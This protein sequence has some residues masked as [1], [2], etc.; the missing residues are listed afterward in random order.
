MTK[1]TGTAKK[2][3][4]KVSK[5]GMKAIGAP[6]KAIGRYI[7]ATESALVPDMCRVRKMAPRNIA[8]ALGRDKSS[9]T[10][11]LFKKPG[12][13]RVGRKPP[14]SGKDVQKPLKITKAK[15]TPWVGRQSS[16]WRLGS[17]PGPRAGPKPGRRT[18]RSQEARDAGRW[19]EGGG[20]AGG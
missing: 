7:N 13:G 11:H 18:T 8:E 19:V 14:L 12:R 4:G 17:R 3:I 6:K 1:A 10:R 5:K 16:P 20:G 9:V 15:Q 2:A